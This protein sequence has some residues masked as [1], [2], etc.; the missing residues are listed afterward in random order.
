M[1]VYVCTRACTAHK[2]RICKY[3]GSVTFH[4]YS[5]ASSLV[6]PLLWFLVLLNVYSY[7]TVTMEVVHHSSFHL[8]TWKKLNAYV[9]ITTK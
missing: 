3:A 4:V 9:V 8:L 2:T 1:F 7:K 5:S 6:W